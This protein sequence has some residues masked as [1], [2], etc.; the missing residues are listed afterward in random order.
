MYCMWSTT[1]YKSRNKEWRTYSRHRTLHW[2]LTKS[3]E[4][5]NATVA[6]THDMLEIQ[7]LHWSVLISATECFSWMCQLP[8]KFYTTCIWIQ[9]ITSISISLTKMWATRH[10]QK[11]KW[12][13]GITIN[14]LFSFQRGSKMYNATVTKATWWRK[15]HDYIYLH[16]P[17]AHSY[18]SATAK[19]LHEFVHGNCCTTCSEITDG[20]SVGRGFHFAFASPPISKLSEPSLLASPCSLPCNSPAGVDFLLPAS[21]RLYVPLWG[22]R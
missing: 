19:L 8:S 7:T 22:D 10:N 16:M 12:K 9:Q 6:K 5:Y 1:W 18:F 13:A 11:A 2:F 20:S 21:S 14:A 17:N 4:M 3:S 15:L